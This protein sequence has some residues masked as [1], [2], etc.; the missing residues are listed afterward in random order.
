MNSIRL[1]KEYLKQSDVALFLFKE[2]DDENVMSILSR[3]KFEEHI[4]PRSQKE[5]WYI[6]DKKGGY[7]HF[8][9]LIY[10]KTPQS[11]E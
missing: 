3:Y 6:L 2:E 10:Q 8:Q 7:S 11:S 9:I 1:F 4:L 5:Y